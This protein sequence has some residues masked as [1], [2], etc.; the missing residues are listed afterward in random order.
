MSGG[1]I[2]IDNNNGAKMNES[3]SEYFELAPEDEAGL[4]TF[5]PKSIFKLD[6][7]MTRLRSKTALRLLLKGPS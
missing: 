5:R 3:T 6:G 7:L 2:Q 1:G 4:R